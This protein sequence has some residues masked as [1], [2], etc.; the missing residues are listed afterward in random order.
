MITD[1]YTRPTSSGRMINYNSTRPMRMEIDT[2]VN[3]TRKVL[4][5]SDR[6]YR[7]SNMD[8]IYRIL[9]ADNYPTQLI[10]ELVS[11]TL[12]CQDG[13][14]REETKIG[15]IY[16]SVPYIPELT[17]TGRLGE[18]ITDRATMMAHKSDRTLEHIFTDNK[19]EQ[20]KLRQDN[21]VYGMECNGN[22]K[23][24]CNLV[25]IGTTG[26]ELTNMKQT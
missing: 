18:I 1:W 5:I 4:G 20:D 15:E 2:A 7:K 17:E 16:Y 23:G 22:D 9:A 13:E 25:Y 3:F 26:G 24:E 10:S 8:K 6:E 19:T 11:R 21:V 12:E 14:R